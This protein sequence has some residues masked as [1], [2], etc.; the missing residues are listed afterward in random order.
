M[1]LH[2]AKGLEFPVVFLIGLE[3]GVFPHLRSLGEPDE[4]EEER[5]LAYVGIT[6]ARERLL[7]EPRLEPDALRLH[8]VQPAEPLPRRDP[9]R[10]ASSTSR[11]AGGGSRR[12]AGAT[13][14]AAAAP[15]RRSARAATAIVERALTRPGRPHAVSGAEAPRACGSATTC[16]T[17]SGARA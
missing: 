2:S 11:A 14:G 10:A 7:P 16:A 17:P 4:L 6:R 13:G 9:G 1:T 8:A 12:A 5:R 15:A 3:D